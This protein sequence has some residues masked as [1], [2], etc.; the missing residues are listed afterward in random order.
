L[1][2]LVPNVFTPATRDFTQALN[3]S[4]SQTVYQTE[5]QLPDTVKQLSRDVIQE[6]LQYEISDVF[7]ELSPL[8]ESSLKTISVQMH[9]C[10][11]EGISQYFQQLESMP[12]ST[13]YQSVVQL[14]ENLNQTVQNLSRDHNNSEPIKPVHFPTAP[15]VTSGIG[16]Q[17]PTPLTPLSASREMQPGNLEQIYL[18]ISK[19][20]YQNALVLALSAENLQVL[21]SVCYAMDLSVFRTQH[22]SLIVLLSFAQQLSYDFISDAQKKLEWLNAALQKIHYNPAYR[23]Q[24]LITLPQIESNIR[25]GLQYFHEHYLTSEFMALRTLEQQLRTIQ[26]SIH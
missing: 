6:T 2:E 12:T 25:E 19:W 5:K 8:F 1:M 26:L 18:A 15:M 24:I 9:N 14:T 3:T 20:D 4:L 11:Q 7:F 22:I 23:N 10:F 21:M 17:Y 13:N 16:T